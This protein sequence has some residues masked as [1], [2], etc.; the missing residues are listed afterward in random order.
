[1]INLVIRQRSGVFDLDRVA[2]MTGQRIKTIRVILNF[3]E[4]KGKILIK[5]HPDTN[6]IISYGETEDKQNA[7]F[8]ENQLRFLFQET[9]YFQKWYQKINAAQLMDEIVDLFSR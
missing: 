5:E 9:L 8:Y 6:L 2:A 3:L 1:M 4:A 7:L